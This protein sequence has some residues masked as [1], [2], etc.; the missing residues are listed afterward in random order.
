MQGDFSGM[1]KGEQHG[2]ASDLY[3]QFQTCLLAEDDKLYIKDTNRK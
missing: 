1:V 2:T 3:A